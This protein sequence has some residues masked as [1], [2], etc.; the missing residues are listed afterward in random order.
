M[1]ALQL[2][3]KLVWINGNVTIKDGILWLPD[4]TTIDLIEVSQN[5]N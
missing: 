5:K 4:G 3:D 1:N 2:V